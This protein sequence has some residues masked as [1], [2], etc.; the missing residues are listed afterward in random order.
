[1]LGHREAFGGAYNGPKVLLTVPTTGRI[2]KEI[3]LWLLKIVAYEN[4]LSRC[5]GHI[6]LPTDRPYEQTQHTI[7]LDLLENDYD[8]WVSVDDDNPPLRNVLDLIFLEKDLI[9][10]PTPVWKYDPSKAERPFMWNAYDYDP[11]ED[12]YREHEDKTGLQSVDAIGTGC[13]VAAQR[14]F[15]H[16]ALRQGAFTRKLKSN[17]LVY[18]GNDISF[19]ERFR[20]AGFNIFAHYEYPCR[21]F[22]TID[23]FDCATAFGRLVP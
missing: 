13:F 3:L 21:H 1:M 15:S 20:S 5:H 11:E 14:C 10:C 4:R 23:L 7:V 17:G 2:R 18:K 19:C 22:S 8:Y 12:A 9:G 6:C 16:H